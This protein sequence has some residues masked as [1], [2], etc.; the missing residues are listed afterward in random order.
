MST[1]RRPARGLEPAPD[2]VVL[3][4]YRLTDRIGD[5]AGTSLWRAVDQRLRR[6][7]AVRF[8]PLDNVLA[9]PLREAVSRASLVTDRRAVPVLDIVAD[10]HAGHLVV[11]TEWVIGTPL[12]EHLVARQGDPLPPRDAAAVALEVA[13]FLA[14]AEAEGIAHAHVRP[15]AVMISD[16]AEVRVRGLGVDR[17]LYGVVPELDPELADVHGAGAVLYAGLTGR[18]PTIDGEDRLPG[19]PSLDRGRIPWP[20]RVVADVPPALDEI[21][22]RCLRTCQAPKGTT[23]FT[24]VAE[25]VVALTSAMSVAPVVENPRRWRPAIRVGSVILAGAAAFGLAALGVAMLFGL[26]GSP[27]TVPRTVA[28]DRPGSATPTPVGPATGGQRDLPIVSVVDFDPYGDTKE[29]NPEQAKNAIDDDVA[30][31]WRTVRYRADNLSGKPGVGLLLDLGAPRPVSVVALR[32]VG[33]D[34]DLSLRASD[35]PRLAPEKFR[36]IAEVT[37]ASNEVTLPLARPVTTRYILVWL[38]RI[39]SVDGSYQGGV[40]DVRVRG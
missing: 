15:S 6:P 22:A 2:T 19:V 32:L 7:V 31:A 10:D 16:T 8:M 36:S 29:E 13:R 23:H 40:S 38:T 39:P 25:V 17:V 35:N 3:D 21:A 30:S 26:G 27:L 24:S 9:V 12:S 20:S 28:Q 5:T 4:R 11:V 34:T 18:W 14:A 33:N 1:R 37:G